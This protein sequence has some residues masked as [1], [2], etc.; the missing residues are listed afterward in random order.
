MDGN[1]FDR[2]SRAIVPGASRRRLLGLLSSLPIAGFLSSG[3]N[4]AAKPG[5]Q[6]HRHHAQT[7]SRHA[8]AQ[9]RRDQRNG[10]HSE[11]CIPTGKRCPA[12]K[13]RGKKGKKLGCTQCCQQTTATNASGQKVCACQPT[14]TA[15]TTETAFACCTGICTTGACS[16]GHCPQ[17]SGTTPIC[18]G[19]IC[20]ACTSTSQ[21][22]AN[23]LCDVASGACLPCDVCPSGCLFT[24]VQ[25]AIDATSPQL[26]TIR[27]C[28]GTYV[29]DLEIPRTVT[30]LG[31][32]DGPGAGSTILQGTGTTQV[33]AISLDDQDVTL[34]NLRITGGGGST[35]GAGITTDGRSLTMTDCTVTGNTD[36]NQA[37]GLFV[38]GGTAQL[39]RCTISDNHTT[40]VASRGGGISNGGQTTLTDCV[41]SGNSAGDIGGG[42]VNLGP[43]THL[44]LVNTVVSGN[45]ATTGAGIYVMSG[46][47]VTLNNS[48]VGGAAPGAANIATT[49]GGIF[50][51]SGTVTLNAGTAVCGNVPD[52]CVGFAD[53]T[54]C[55]AMCPP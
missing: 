32:G 19:A 9:R 25:T 41:V 23:T 13:P 12:R 44:T 55:L 22:P 52:Q 38:S 31:A 3:R 29:G 42:I 33:V 40:D 11:A 24:S 54:H 18:Q 21:C 39:T 4:T 45:H 37:G 15:C 5:H 49:G 35:N 20:M 7:Q 1:A 46:S 28:P 10:A 36:L 27:I 16:A 50:L 6:T 53:P 8:R 26:T 30:L 14:G 34:R 43:S 51:L 2:L 48:L 17:C 47:S